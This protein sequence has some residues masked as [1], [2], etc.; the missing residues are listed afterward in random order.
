MGL[1]TTDSE[2]HLESPGSTWESQ[3]Q[4]RA[5]SEKKDHFCTNTRTK[6]AVPTRDNPQI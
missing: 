1:K 3:S 6:A 4:W 5:T 2:S